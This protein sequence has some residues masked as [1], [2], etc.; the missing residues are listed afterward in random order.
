MKNNTKWLACG[1]LALAACIALSGCG[2]SSSSTTT[3]AST[4]ASTTAVSGDLAAPTDFTVDPETGEFSFTAND[5]NMGYYFVRVYSVIDGVEQDQY[6]TS[7]SRINGGSTGTLSGTFD[8]S[9]IGWGSYH[10]KL[11]SFVAAGTDANAPDSVTLTANYG[12]GGVLEKPEMLVITDGKQAEFIIDHYTLSDYKAYQYLPTVTFNVYSDAECTTLVKSE[13]FDTN[14]LTMDTHPA[15]GYIWEYSNNGNHPYVSGS[16]LTP[17]VTMEDLE[18]G[19]YYVTCQAVSSD[20]TAISSSQVSDVVEFTVTADEPTGE[21]TSATTSLWQD[22][23]VMGMPCAVAGTYTDR[24][25]FGATQT[26]SASIA[27]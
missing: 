10:I 12:V 27:E 1:A 20:E 7:S 6:V 11:V 9:G 25:D 8:V 14:T 21:F 22:P 18:P 26:T 23:Q 19:T 5:E 17:E 13:S 24:V 2:G 15:G 16:T 3:A 4:A